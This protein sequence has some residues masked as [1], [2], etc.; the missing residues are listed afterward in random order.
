MR[1]PSRGPRPGV[2]PPRAGAL[3]FME[4]HADVT[5]VGIPQSM[6]PSRSTRKLKMTT[7]LHP[8]EVRRLVLRTFQE[9]DAD[10]QALRKLNENILVREGKYAARSYHIEGYMAMWMVEVGVLQFYD[11]DGNMLR[12]VNLLE[13]LGPQTMAAA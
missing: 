7:T 13:E 1:G 2:L 5:F 4:T 11:V 12:T 9:F 6:T 3:D 8:A 10:E